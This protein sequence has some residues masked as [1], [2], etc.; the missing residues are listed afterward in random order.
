MAEKKW[1]TGVMTLL[2]GDI[3]PCI[4]IVGAHLVDIE[5]KKLP[6]SKVQLMGGLVVSSGKTS[7]YHPCIVYEN[8]RL[9]FK[10]QPNAG[11]YTIITWDGMGMFGVSSVRLFSLLRSMMEPNP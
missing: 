2:I 5:E 11:K 9:P 7:P 3:T 4:T 1:V 6:G 10:N 8:L